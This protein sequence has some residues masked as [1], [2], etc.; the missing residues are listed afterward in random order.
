MF[1]FGFGDVGFCD[2]RKTGVPGEKP[3][4]KVRTNSKLNPHMTL[5]QNH[6]QATFS[7]R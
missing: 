1:E 5:N 6:T 7:G 3:L 2:G 4:E